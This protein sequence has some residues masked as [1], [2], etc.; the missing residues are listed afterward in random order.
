MQT[1][2]DSLYKIPLQGGKEIKFFAANRLP[3]T[4]YRQSNIKDD[5][6]NLHH[7]CNKLYQ[8][9]PPERFCRNTNY[10]PK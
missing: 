10:F 3:R 1:Y 2:T 9:M 8:G 6:A 7:E 4:K 5:S